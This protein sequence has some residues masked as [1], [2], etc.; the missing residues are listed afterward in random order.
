MFLYKLNTEILNLFLFPNRW[1][2][3]QDGAVVERFGKCV[4]E[5]VAVQ[6]RDTLEWALPGVRN[7]GKFSACPFFSS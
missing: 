2:R 6:L 7:Y 1:K 5:F 3:T 4:M